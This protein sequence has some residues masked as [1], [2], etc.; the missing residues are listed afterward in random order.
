[1]AGISTC[2]LSLSIFPLLF[3]FCQLWRLRTARIL[4]LNPVSIE[5]VTLESAHTDMLQREIS[6][7]LP[8]VPDNSCTTLT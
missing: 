6:L 4:D 2:F 8:L 3:T 7:T 1:M 5:S